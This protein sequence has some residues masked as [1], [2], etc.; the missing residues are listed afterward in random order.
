MGYVM[1]KT[2]IVSSQEK[3]FIDDNID[4][5]SSFEKISALRGETVSLQF[6]YVDSSEGEYLPVR[7]FFDITLSGDIAKYATMRDVR[8]VPVDRPTKPGITD[9]NYLRMIPGIYPDILTPLRYGGK[10]CPSR[11]KLRSVWIEISIPEDYSGEYTLNV[12]ASKNDI[13]VVNTEIVEIKVIPVSLP[14][15]KTHFTQWFYPDCL[16]AYYNVPMWSEK[17]W[18][19]VESFARVAVKRGRDTL[20]MPLFTPAIN[21]LPGYERLSSQLVRI[22]V[23]NGEYSFDFSLVD[24]YV[25]MC[26]R[27]GVKYLEISHFYQQDNAKH[28]AHVY[29]TV[30]GEYKQV[31]D[32]D[33][34]ALDE[35]YVKF[36]RLLVGEFVEHMKAR[37][38]DERCIYHIS[39]EPYL[40]NI[41]HYRAVK[42]N[43]SDLLSGYKII[44]ALSDFE[45]YSKGILEHPVPVLSAADSFIEAN[46][47]ELWV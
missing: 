23:N 9:E 16:A 37:G 13:G 7:P 47:K 42:E 21:V 4:A 20:Y 10:I 19:I 32:W 44:D 17:H 1:L 43:V 11:D 46:V 14:E 24:R 15:Q 40:S 31:F 2:K 39:D 36:L 18:E 33:S 28:A 12:T 8:C 5:F 26:D 41:E 25:D 35:E 3:I 34:L 45:F 27:L 38:D 22:N 6:L 29:A 30:D